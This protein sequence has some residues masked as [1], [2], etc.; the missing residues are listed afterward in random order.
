MLKPPANLIQTPHGLVDSSRFT[1]NAVL[2]VFERIGGVDRLADEADKD[3]KWFFEKMMRTLI[4]PEK[5]EISREKTI[6]EMLAELDASMVDITPDR[7][8]SVK[9]VIEGTTGEED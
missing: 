3:A 5:I 8:G 2:E 9:A 6:A 4:Q 7:A 1:R